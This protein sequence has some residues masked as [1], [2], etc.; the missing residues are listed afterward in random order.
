MGCAERGCFEETGLRVQ[1]RKI[2]Y[3]QEF[4][5]DGRRACKHWIPCEL[6]EGEINLDQVTDEESDIIREEI[7]ALNVYPRLMLDQFWNDYSSGFPT[8]HHL[9]FE[10]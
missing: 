6:I 8:T 2:A 4:F 1:A 10:S 5:D 9:A 7:K 3:I